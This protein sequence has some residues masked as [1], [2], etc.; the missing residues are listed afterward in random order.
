M[1]NPQPTDA[2]LRIAHSIEEEIMMRDFTKRQRSIM[3]LVLRLSWGCGKKT[4][5]IP[6]Q[7]DFELVG[8]D[9]TKIRTE[10]EW[11]VN[12][13]VISRD[14]SGKEYSFN[15]NY[16]EWRVS[17]VS[18]YNK[19]RFA[20]L[21]SLNIRTCQNSK[22]LAETASIQED[23]L[24][25]KASAD[26]T[27]KQVL[28][29]AN[30]TDT[31]C[32]GPPKESSNITTTTTTTTTDIDNGLAK[33]ASQDEQSGRLPGAPEKDIESDRLPGASEEP[34]AVE[35]IGEYYFKVTSRFANSRDFVSITEVL[36]HPIAV[37]IDYK[38]RIKI[39]K[40]AMDRM[41]V[42][43]NQSNNP[44]DKI[45]SFS[46]FRNG[47]YEDYRKLEIANN[48]RM[49]TTGIDSKY[50]F[51]VS[52]VKKTFSPPNKGNFE[53]RQYSDEDYD[54]LYKDV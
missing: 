4:A 40:Q 31:S 9:Q 16:D 5:Y 45:N 17:I 15:K 10:I 25:E 8:I 12:A 18:S 7:K 38:S 35:E 3:D 54:K 41:S 2:H 19:N 50:A 34:H 36:D 32:T 28:I 39:I 42:Q 20:E 14:P 30:P 51:K 1:A 49:D 13:K 23:G 26:L 33:T 24:D 21:L 22:P 52:P 27:K 11:L 47:I 48:V 29:T 46:F 37:P 44:L 53:Q 6:M 43:K